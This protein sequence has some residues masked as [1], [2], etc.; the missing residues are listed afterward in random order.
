MKTILSPVAIYA[1]VLALA[2]LAILPGC[3]ASHLPPPVASHIQ[4]IGQGAV[5]AGDDYSEDAPAS[6]VG[7]AQAETAHTI[8]LLPDDP[9]VDTAYAI[10]C[11][12]DSPFHIRKSFRYAIEQSGGVE[13]R[14]GERVYILPDPHVSVTIGS[15]V[16]VASSPPTQVFYISIATDDGH[17]GSVCPE[18]A[19]DLIGIPDAGTLSAS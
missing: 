4:G 13:I 12:V 16:I 2:A 10:A 7:D 19:G 9:M 11:A 5:A 1:S 8:Y 17:A 14:K 3:S 6:T 18:Q 15:P